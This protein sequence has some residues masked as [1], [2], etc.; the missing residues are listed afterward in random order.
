MSRV[1]KLTPRALSAARA[2][3]GAAEYEE[4]ATAE[5]L[6]RSLTGEEVA[7]IS[8]APVSTY[9]E[10]FSEE[11]AFRPGDEPAVFLWRRTPSYGHWC[12]AWPLPGARD[13]RNR[14][15]GRSIAVFDPYGERVPDSWDRWSGAEELGQ[16]QM[17]ILDAVA[18]GLYDSME[19]H[20]YPMQEKDAAV[21][22]CGR[23]AALRVALSE[24]TPRE[25]ATSVYATCE[26]L[27]SWPDDL[28]VRLTRP[29]LRS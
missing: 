1:K 8:G 27:D 12:V 2:M 17:R 11:G 16:D 6:A 14:R 15:E 4:P 26:A 28:V 13:T 22:T 25:F 5:E 7:A 10:V 24:L 3:Y 19:W 20:D 18:S 29:L 21:A 23:W 9:D